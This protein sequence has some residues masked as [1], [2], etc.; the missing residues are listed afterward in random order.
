MYQKSKILLTTALTTMLLV[1][2]AAYGAED[3]T[4]QEIKDGFRKHAALTQLHRWYLLYEEPAYGIDNQL[5]I[6]DANVALK[7]GLG[8]GKGHEQYVE[9]VKQIPTTWKNAHDVKTTSVTVNDDGS[10]NLM[11]NITYLNQG[12]LENEVVRTAELTYTT[13][14]KP[15]DAVLPKFTSIVIAQDSDGTAEEFVAEYGNNRM[16]SLVHY[17]L[18]LIEDPSRNAEPVKEILAD[19]FSL[20]FSSGAITD[21][22]GFEAWLAGPGSAVIAS[23][24]KIGEFN[25]E[26]LESGEYRVSM[27]FDWNG[28]LPNNAEMTAKT[29][30]TWLVVDDPTKRFAQIK[31]V[32][33]EV[34]EPF[35][36]KG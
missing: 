12:L 33:V 14:L 1:A 25:Q 19:R 5:D 4:T 7:S 26:L 28:I 10:V 6:L 24:H 23:T 3:M 13:T 21:F 35:K 8:E 9:R 11:A 36:P 22:A 18:A 2:P 20:N 27:T 31:S 34:L 30:H 15:T 32:D 17:W 29:K 16:R